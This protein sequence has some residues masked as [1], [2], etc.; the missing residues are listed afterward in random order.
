MSRWKDKKNGRRVKQAESGEGLAAAP[1][2]DDGSG[3]DALQ[4]AI[5]LTMN[6]KVE[7]MYRDAVEN[8]KSEASEMVH[9]L[10]LSQIRKMAPQLAESDPKMLIGEERHRNEFKKKIEMSERNV[11]QYEI[12]T[13]MQQERIRMLDEKL[14]I[15]K[16]KAEDE[17]QKVLEARRI[18]E[19][20]RT[21]AEVGQPMDAMAVYNQIAEIVGLRP[22]KNP[23]RESVVVRTSG[24]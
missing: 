22:P 21:A 9:I 19:Q 5:Y 12:R 10:L 18:T 6:Q 20:A 3:P 16:Q 11:E 17:H 24:G 8:P 13:K 2:R 1:M 14:A 15:E 4:G 23:V 7:K